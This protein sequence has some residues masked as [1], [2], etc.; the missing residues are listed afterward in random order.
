MVSKAIKAGARLRGGAEKA[1]VEASRVPE[2]RY[3]V[4]LI[5]WS[6]LT[7]SNLPRSQRSERCKIG[8][9]LQ[10][11]EDILESA[12]LYIVGCIC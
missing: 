6:T 9:L 7:P 10:K 5:A 12:E 4:E 3:I 11:H 2:A 8:Q 1:A